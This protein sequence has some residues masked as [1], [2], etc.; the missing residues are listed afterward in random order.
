MA[1]S[2]DTDD[3]EFALKRPS[4]LSLQRVPTESEDERLHE[5]LE[6]RQHEEEEERDQHHRGAKRAGHEVLCEGCGLCAATC[7][8]GYIDVAGY[9]DE[10]VFAQLGALGPLPEVLGP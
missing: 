5:L 10:Q 4:R 1:S 7:R 8:G 9:S 3:G 6:Q 2:D